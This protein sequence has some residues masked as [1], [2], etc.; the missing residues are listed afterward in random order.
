MIG[1]NST[2]LHIWDI[3]KLFPYGKLE[4]GRIEKQR[5]ENILTI[6]KTSNKESLAWSQSIHAYA[7]NKRAFR[8]VKWIEALAPARVQDKKN[9]HYAS[10]SRPHLEELKTFLNFSVLNVWNLWLGTACESDLPAIPWVCSMKLFQLSPA[11]PCA[12]VLSAAAAVWN[13]AR[14]PSPLHCTSSFQPSIAMSLCSCETFCKLLF[15][16]PNLL[17]ESRQQSLA[18]RFVSCQ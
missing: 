15:Q 12:Q 18:L 13:S 16:R 7:L 1:K 10:S 14:G 11:A 17:G 2:R 9:F 8:H 4:K 5:E 3:G 6:L